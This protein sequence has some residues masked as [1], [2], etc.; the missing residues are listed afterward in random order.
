MISVKTAKAKPRARPLM[1]AAKIS[2]HRFRRV[3]MGFVRDHSATD[4]AQLTGLSL[5]SVTAI[6]GKLRVY[7]WEI[8]LF[9]DIYDGAD[10]LSHSGNEPSFEKAL[11]EYHLL[12]V[13]EKNGL[14][15][16][17]HGPDYHFAESHWRYHFQVL[18]RER[19]HHD[20]HA[21]MFSH[22]IEIIRLCGPIGLK[23]FNRRSGIE[24]VLRQMDQRIAWLE[25]NAPGFRGA[26]HRAELNAIRAL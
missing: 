7:F 15:S 17:A 13:R 10:P 19:V 25:R 22:L 6:F 21:M 5:N 26:A 16:S 1:H 9:T 23:P 12:R 8:G 14:K 4:T 18:M 2:D 20:V 24:A 3:L 11:L